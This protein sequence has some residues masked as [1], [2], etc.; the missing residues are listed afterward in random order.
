MDYTPG[1]TCARLLIQ[2]VPPIQTTKSL[3]IIS[4]EFQP[5]WESSA[6]SSSPLHSIGQLQNFKSHSLPDVSSDD[7]AP[8]PALGCDN[9]QT[10]QSNHRFIVIQSGKASAE[11]QNILLYPSRRAPSNIIANVGSYASQPGLINFRD[12]LSWDPRTRHYT[13]KM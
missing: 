6:M 3:L 7:T 12:T 13:T 4:P 2:F 11:L 10:G 1:Y 8:V 5:R 9:V